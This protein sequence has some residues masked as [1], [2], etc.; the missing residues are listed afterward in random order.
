MLVGVLGVAYVIIVREY[1]V[2][3]AVL[4]FLERRNIYTRAKAKLRMRMRVTVIT[5]FRLLA[6]RLYAPM[7][8]CIYTHMW[9]DA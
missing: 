4:L 9:E 5:G 6:N 1:L 7:H 8:V 2:K 3:C